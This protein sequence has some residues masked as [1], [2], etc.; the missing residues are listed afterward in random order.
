MNIIS[1]KILKK[2]LNLNLFKLTNMHH[3]SGVPVKNL[4][5]SDQLFCSVT[6][7]NEDSDKNTS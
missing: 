5:F 1:F 4:N 2:S 6:Y 7:I 3:H